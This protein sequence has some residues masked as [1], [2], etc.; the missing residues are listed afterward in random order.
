MI[1]AVFHVQQTDPNMSPLPAAAQVLPTWK[2]PAALGSVDPG[3]PVAWL[4]ILTKVIQL[5]AMWHFEI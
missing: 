1:A 2:S 5:D 3:D 4:T